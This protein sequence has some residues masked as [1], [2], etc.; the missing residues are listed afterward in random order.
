MQ[1]LKDSAPGGELRSKKWLF[2]LV[3]RVFQMEMTFHRMKAWPGGSILVGT[4]MALALPG[5]S[6]AGAVVGGSARG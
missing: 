3:L 5:N 6:F 2:W 4:G 1:Q